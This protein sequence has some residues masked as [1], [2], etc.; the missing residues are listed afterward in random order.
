MR[1]RTSAARAILN[2][3]CK[4]IAAG[5]CIKL[6]SKQHAL[7]AADFEGWARTERDPRP[8]LRPCDALLG[9]SASWR[10]SGK[11]LPPRRSGQQGSGAGVQKG[12]KL[13]SETS[14]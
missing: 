5:L 10:W 8:S 7:V 2:L 12:P 11:T 3:K 13:R 9:L 14:R 6:T 1:R 4:L